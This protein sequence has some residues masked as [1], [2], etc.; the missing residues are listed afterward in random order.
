METLILWIV[1]DRTP[2]NVF[3]A[4]QPLTPRGFGKNEIVIHP[5]LGKS[6]M[7]SNKRKYFLEEE[8]TKSLQPTSS[9]KPSEPPLKKPKFD[10]KCEVID[11]HADYV[12]INN[13]CG[14]E[15]FQM[16]SEKIQEYAKSR[17]RAGIKFVGAYYRPQKTTVQGQIVCAPKHHEIVRD[18]IFSRDCTINGIVFTVPK[19]HSWLD[20]L[21]AFKL[22]HDL[23]GHIVSSITKFEWILQEGTDM[24]RRMCLLLLS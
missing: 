12:F 6:I 21:D 23:T 4:G 11:V 17:I 20:I 13:G 9:E 24:E 10:Y 15:F 8:A 2:T 18:F 22:T 19:T 5:V 3:D 16:P 7:Q 14:K 1:P